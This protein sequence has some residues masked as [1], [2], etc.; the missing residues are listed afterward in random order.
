LAE[1]HIPASVPTPTTP[2]SGIA[3]IANI[4]AVAPRRHR[5]NECTAKNI[6]SPY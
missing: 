5:M 3:A 6:G 2:I 4:I 1:Y